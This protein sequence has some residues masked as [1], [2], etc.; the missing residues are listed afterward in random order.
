MEIASVVIKIFSRV[1]ACLM[2]SIQGSA[3]ACAE[4][5]SN[6]IGSHSPHCLNIAA[7]LGFLSR[8]QSSR[9]NGHIYRQQ[10]E[11]TPWCLDNVG[12]K[13]PGR[14]VNIYSKYI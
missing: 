6:W 8:K 1:I 14:A 2:W 10:P 11:E 9:T 13:N 4:V 5:T 12:D 7:D 3:P